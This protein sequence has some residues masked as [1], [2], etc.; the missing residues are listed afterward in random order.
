[1]APG[2]VPT[3]TNELDADDREPRTLEAPE[4]LTDQ[5][6]TNPVGFYQHECAFNQV[7]RSSVHG[8]PFSYQSGSAVS[9]R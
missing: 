5:P 4:Y 1:M 8:R 9:V 7:V 3:W 6:T 2:I